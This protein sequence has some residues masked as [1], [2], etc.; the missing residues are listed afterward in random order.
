MPQICHVHAVS[1]LC[2]DYRQGIAEAMENPSLI[3]ELMLKIAEHYGVDG[4][5]IFLTP[6]AVK[7]KDDGETM[8]AF[9]GETGKRLGRVDLLGGAAVI[10]DEEGMRIETAEEVKKIPHVRCEDLLKTAPYERLRKSTKRAHEMGFFV[11][12]APTDYVIKAVIR[13]RGR[14]QTYVDLLTEPDLVKRIME[15]ELANAIEVS[16][17]LI[18]CGID[19][20]YTGDPSSSCSLISPGQWE[21]FC[22]PIFKAL[23][24]EV[25]KEGVMVYMHIC[26]NA[27]P[28]LEMMADTGADCIEPLDPLGGVEVADAKRRVGNRVALMGGVNTLTLSQGSA[29]EVYEEAMACCRDGG[30]GGGYILAAGDMVPD[31]SP[32]ENVKALVKAARDSRY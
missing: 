26:G 1:V 21:E 25:H 28:I 14:E 19:A 5:R 2:D 6:D 24:K 18:K 3:D 27:K 17:A 22:L 12:S 16:R 13:Y 20:I 15:A 10:P 31:H 30:G 29:E 23:C 4:L 11:A 7:V 8:V 9:D 32:E